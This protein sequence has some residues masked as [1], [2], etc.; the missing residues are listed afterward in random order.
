MPWRPAFKETVRD[1]SIDVVEPTHATEFEV[2]AF[3]WSALK[4]LG[5]NARGEV[6]CRF[7]GRAGG[8]TQGEIMNKCKTQGRLLI[9]KLRK[10][11]HTYMD[12]LRYGI[13]TSPWKRIREALGMDEQLLKVENRQG[14]V[15]W[16]VVKACR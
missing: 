12:M 7:K 14:L 16:R 2:Q 3:L 11:P 9:E 8:L 15:T 1:R 13:S 5:I 4:Q 6:K 10:K